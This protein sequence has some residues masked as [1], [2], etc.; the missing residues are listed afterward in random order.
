VEVQWRFPVK[1][2]AGIQQ[3]FGSAAWQCGLAYVGTR[4]V[5]VEDH[6]GYLVLS[7]LFRGEWSYRFQGMGI[8]L[9]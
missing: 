1:W 5:G 8:T 9:I 2:E 6:Y 4:E 3:N 7:P